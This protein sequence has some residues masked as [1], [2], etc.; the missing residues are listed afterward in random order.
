VSCKGF[1]LQPSKP[2]WHPSSTLDECLSAQKIQSHFFFTDRAYRS[3]GLLL[4][5]LSLSSPPARIF[6]YDAP[7]SDFFGSHGY[8]PAVARTFTKNE[9]F[10]AIYR[11]N[12]E[13]P[14]SFLASFSIESISDIESRI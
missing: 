1:N 14:D 10:L 13:D 5:C 4:S 3:A 11:P 9:F 6:E 7:S 2:L 8:R 12:Q